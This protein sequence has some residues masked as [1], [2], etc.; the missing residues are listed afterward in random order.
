[1]VC[2]SF[3]PSGTAL[4]GIA[5]DATNTNNLPDQDD[6]VSAVTSSPAAGV[7]V[8]TV[9]RLCVVPPIGYHYYQWTENSYNGATSTWY[10]KLTTLRQSGLIGTW[11]C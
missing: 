6:G 2:Y 9:G 8:A 1:M 3:S 10:S 5:I 7:A 4:A 11:M